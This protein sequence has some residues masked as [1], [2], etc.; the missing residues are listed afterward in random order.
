MSG[1]DGAPPPAPPSSSPDGPPAEPHRRRPRY[2]GTHPRRFDER[3]K[4]LDP[5]RF[6]ELAAH[7]RAQGRTPAGSHVP[8]L[9]AEVLE[10]LHPAPGETVADLTLGRGGHARAL[11]GRIGPAGRLLA[12]DLDRDELARTRADLEAEGHG[13]RLTVHAGHFASLPDGIRAAGLEAVDVVFADLGLSSMQIDDPARGFSYK[14]DGPLDMRMDRAR[15]RTA[16]EVLAK[17]PE[18][19]LARA[20]EELADEPHAARIA[21]AVVARRATAPLLRTGD[22]VEAA[23]AGVGLTPDAW[24]ARAEREVRVVH[25]AARTFQAVRILVNDELSGLDRLLALVPWCLRPGGRIGILS[26]H[27]GEDRRVKHAFRAGLDAGLYDAV[28][29]DVVR[30]SP[31]E[32]AANPR[33]ASAKLRWARRAR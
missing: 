33:A 4:E 15:G 23:L 27:S 25:P 16:A 31:R 24:R 5:A 2:R 1:T 3:Y 30:A 14:H 7:V 13:P 8:I 18:V 29:D 28:A 17:I 6:P 22:L 12:F 10:A 32:V 21:A 11:L 19:D 9:V 20:L 26:F